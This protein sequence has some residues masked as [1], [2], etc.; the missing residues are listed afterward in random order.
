[1]IEQYEHAVLEWFHA[2]YPRITEMVYGKQD[3]ILESKTPTLRYPCLTYTREDAENIL[4]KAIVVKDDGVDENG[5]FTQSVMYSVPTDYEAHLYLNNERDLYK[6]LNILRQKWHIES[7]VTIRYPDADD[8]LR[9]AMRLLSMKMQT[10]KSGVDTKGPKRDI[11]IKW[12]SDLFIEALYQ[13][14]AYTGYRV[15]L[16]AQDGGRK[17]VR[18]TC[19]GDSCKL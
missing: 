7:Y 3:E 1:M 6:V 15:T 14:Q 5:K 9:V 13:Q 8:Q 12:H 18:S 16:V 4:A 10:V 11:T 17:V 19:K 2:A